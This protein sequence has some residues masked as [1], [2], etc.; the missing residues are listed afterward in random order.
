MG[1]DTK[2]VIVGVILGAFVVPMV[3]GAIKKHAK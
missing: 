2:S 3:A 1:L